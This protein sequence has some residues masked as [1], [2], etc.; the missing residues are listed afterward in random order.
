M[1]IIYTYHCNMKKIHNV[2]LSEKAHLNF[3]L[4]SALKGV[5]LLELIESTLEDS[6]DLNPCKIN[7]KSR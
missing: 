2:K 4:R 3:K 7:T 5:T 6:A 1:Q